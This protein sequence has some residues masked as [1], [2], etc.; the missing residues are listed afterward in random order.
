MDVRLTRLTLPDLPRRGPQDIQHLD[1]YVHHCVLHRRC[2]LDLRINLK[3]S[4]KVLNLLENLYKGALVLIKIFYRLLAA[5]HHDKSLTRGM[6]DVT[7]RE[8]DTD[9]D[10]YHSG[11]WEHLPHGYQKKTPTDQ[12]MFTNPTPVPIISENA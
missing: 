3:T 10:K 12:L 7:Y 5:G 9:A 4:E 8:E 6:I 2:W 1:H 11:R